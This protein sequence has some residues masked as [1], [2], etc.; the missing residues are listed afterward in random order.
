MDS[1][2]SHTNGMSNCAHKFAI[3]CIESLVHALCVSSSYFL[4]RASVEYQCI[5]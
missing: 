2:H 5:G 4:P 3:Y 1:I